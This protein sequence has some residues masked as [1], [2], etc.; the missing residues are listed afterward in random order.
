[1]SAR[2][3]HSATAV[4]SPD[5]RL[6]VDQVAM[7][8]EMALEL[9]VTMM[10]EAT[11][12]E[13]GVPW[14]GVDPDPQDG[15]VMIWRDPV[16]RD[17]AL[18]YMRVVIDND[19]TGVAV[20]PVTVKSMD[21]DF[22]GDSV[23]L[24]GGLGELAHA[25]ALETLSVE[26][27]LLDRGVRTE[28]PVY[29]PDAEGEL[30]ATGATREVYPLALHTGLDIET[31]CKDDPQLRPFIDHLTVSANELREQY[32]A[33]QID[34]S[35]FCDRSRAVMAGL[36][37]SV[38]H[39]G[40]ASA[41]DP[42]ALRF[43]SMQSHLRSVQDC[44]LR[45]GKGGRGKLEEYASYLGAQ[46]EFDD[47]EL[48]TGARDTGAPDP[49][50]FDDK[51]RGS[52]AA[53]AFKTQVTGVAGAVSQNA[54]KLARGQ[55]MVRQACELGYPATQS[56]LQAKHDPVDAAYRA[57]MITGPV[58]DLWRGHKMVGEVDPK[59]GRYSWSVVRSYDGTPL[60]ATKDEWMDQFSKMYT[61]PQGMGV[62][63]AT[64]HIGAFADLLSDERGAMIDHKGTEL[65]ML[66]EDSVPLALDRLAYGGKFD[67]LKEVATR[68]ERLYSGPCAGF[69]PRSVLTDAQVRAELERV[70]VELHSGLDVGISPEPGQEPAAFPS[71]K[72]T[73]AEHQRRMPRS[74]WTSRQPGWSRDRAAAQSVQAAQTVQTAPATTPAGFREYQPAPAQQGAVATPVRP[75]QNKGQ[76]V[77]ARID[78]VAASVGPATDAVA[79]SGMGR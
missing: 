19:L 79:D 20:N 66:P 21:G 57:D 8:R 25:E 6:E 22:D 53:M 18:R 33:G 13:L 51:Y 56:V 47:Q 4:W 24:V 74:E 40:F 69:A 55:G 23:G 26:A 34:R 39:D 46:P 15:Y 9:G 45:G 38:F 28:V 49:E 64:E 29:E 17:G 52:Q 14:T 62:P 75:A 63:V 1:M 77:Q 37:G 78:A 32:D 68:R 27:N 72:D 60:Q 16:L 36:S 7:N 67:T 12:E 44:Y 43:D 30:V 41:K 58:K 61:D 35:E 48:V 50:K 65:D 10:D 76:S 11:A 5:P 31:A 3:A 70:G 73:S 59:I 71:R 2:Q 54:V 42:V